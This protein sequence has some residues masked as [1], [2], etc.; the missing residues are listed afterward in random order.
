MPAKTLILAAVCCLFL[1][2]TGL[3]QDE[4]VVAAKQALEAAYDNGDVAAIRAGTTKDHVAIAPHFECMSQAEQLAKIP[5][6]DIKSYEMHGFHT[7]RLTDHVVV[8][9]F[10]ADIDGTF[11]GKPLTP[12]VRVIET[13]VKRDG[14]W[15][16][17]TY[18]ETSLPKPNGS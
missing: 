7:T 5:D 13:W 3:A 17:A 18:Q 6:L 15:L 2:G 16:Q 12:H 1:H 8:L 11:K 10:T 9:T 4:Q 14:K